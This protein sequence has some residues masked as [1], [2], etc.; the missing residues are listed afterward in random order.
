MLNFLSSLLSNNNESV[1]DKFMERFDCRGNNSDTMD[2]DDYTY[3]P[4][5]SDDDSETS[6]LPGPPSVADTSYGRATCYD[7]G[8][9]GPAR[10]YSSTRRNIDGYRRHSSIRCPMPRTMSFDTASTDQTAS[11]QWSGTSGSIST[12]K[13]SNMTRPN[14][15]V[16]PFPKFST[17]ATRPR[18]RL[19][20]ARIASTPAHALRQRVRSALMG[21]QNK[22][23]RKS[24][25]KQL[26][27]VHYSPYVVGSSGG[28]THPSIDHPFDEVPTK[29]T[30]KSSMPTPRNRS[31][32]RMPPLVPISRR[33]RTA[34]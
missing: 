23:G 24:G 18:R 9:D 29:T 17:P 14:V 16:V 4:S 21:R 28:G 12:I 8:Y 13:A 2:D 26:L 1:V 20:V 34:A 30:S 32:S 5:S 19:H 11:T 7:G 25:K 22:V 10:G 6:E 27:A 33:S 3:G 15:T 31:K